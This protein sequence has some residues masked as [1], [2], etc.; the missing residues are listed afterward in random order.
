MT[1]SE[2]K[3]FHLNIKIRMIASFVTDI[4][5]MSI[6]PFMAIYFSNKLGVAWAGG[7]LT[8]TTIISI[9]FSMYGGFWADQFGRKKVM[10]AGYIFQTASFFIIA[11]ANSPW[12]ESVW[13]TFIM[14]FLLSI[15]SR[16]IDPA[17]EALLID[18]SSEEEQPTMY[19]FIYWSTNVAFAIGIVLGG[20]F[21]KTHTFELFL[22]FAILSIFTL[23]FTLGW[24]QDH[25]EP[26]NTRDEKKKGVLSGL[27]S[28]Y[29]N[30]LKD[31]RFMVLCLATLLV[32]SLEFQL[33]GF[34]AVRL[35]EEIQTSL[36]GFTIDGARMLSIL[37]IINTTIVI[38][39]SSII[40]K[41]AR[42]LNLTT[43][44]FMGLLMYVVGYSFLAWNNI[45]V[46]L[47]LAMAI[48]TVGELLF[49]PIRS[50]YVAQLATKEAR[51]SY[52]AISGLSMDAGQVLGSIGLMLSALLS[53][54]MMTGLFL[55]IGAFG[56]LGF[57]WSI[58]DTRLKASEEVAS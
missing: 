43:A 23:T 34:I 38:F 31:S 51:G 46:V 50:T 28:N 29:T 33:Y 5:E 42:K 55:L 39:A 41:T 24:I 48:A 49:Q 26:N 27:L 3:Q 36:L 17:S 54:G 22:G 16:F 2:F 10:V 11:L 53:N 20:L 21:F 13:L 44:L 1:F 9:F 8:F 15:S 30:V 56:M 32:L 4:A 18:V 25:Y 12:F 7:I 37:I 6:F 45:M 19:Q 35:N 52:K 58:Q 47:V 57:Y 40:G 14:F